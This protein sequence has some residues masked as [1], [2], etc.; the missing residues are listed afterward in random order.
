MKKT[1]KPLAL[2]IALAIALS[3]LTFPVSAKVI[4]DGETAEPCYEIFLCPN[5]DG[6]ARFVKEVT[7]EKYGTATI[8]FGMCFIAPQLEHTHDLLRDYELYNCS[9]CGP[10]RLNV[11]TY[12]NCNEQE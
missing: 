2:L 3:V 10:F 5:C 6:S 8:F 11:V 4:D 9:N 7:K 1:R 12:E